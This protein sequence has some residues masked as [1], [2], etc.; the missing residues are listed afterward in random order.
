MTWR[1]HL[2]HALLWLIA[3]FFFAPVA[4]ILLA[5]FKTSEQIL[6]VPPKLLFAPTLDN[7]AR[8]F[9]AA[10]LTH[11]MFNSVVMSV[12]AVVI[13]A[14]CSFLAAFSFSRFKPGGTD[15]LMFLLLSIRM[16]PG[17]AVILPV[18]LM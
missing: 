14:A 1:T 15:F 10:S 16:L 13:A 17:S 5:S 11:E 8:L 9:S 18:Y 3:L 2:Y 7:Y 6:A 12:L 4:W